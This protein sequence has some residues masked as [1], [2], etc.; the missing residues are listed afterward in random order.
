MDNLFLKYMDDRYEKSTHLGE[1][2]T[3]GPIITISRECGCSANVLAETLTT[4]INQYYK[5]K[6]SKTSWKWVSKEILAMA[7]NELKIHPEKVK[8]LLD[9]KE[10][11]FIQSMVDSFT[12]AYYA[13]STRVKKVT[14]DLVRSVAEDGN[15]VLVG[16]AGG[17]IA[18][19]IPNSLHI[20]LVAPL[21]WRVSVM[22][23]KKNMKSDE[24]KKYVLH[25]DKMRDD[26]KSNFV[27]K[28]YEKPEYDL[29]FNCKSVSVELMS[30]LILET[31]IK[32]KLL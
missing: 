28:N 25:M 20:Q 23:L 13:Q 29:S 27:P 21:S 30:D 15:V 24:A 6:G 5:E 18:S 17:I 8:Q 9:A 11:N 31:A 14:A 7:A 10:R 2:S 22:A 32:R 1:K 19:D 3:T 4:K 12:D 16:R 26:F